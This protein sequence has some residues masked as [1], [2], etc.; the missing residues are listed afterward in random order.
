MDS[1]RLNNTDLSLQQDGG[2]KITK[3]SRVLTT[4]PLLTYHEAY[5]PETSHP[6]PAAL[7][8]INRISSKA[9]LESLADE[10]SSVE[11]NSATLESLSKMST[12]SRRLARMQMEK[13]NSF[14]FDKKR[15]SSWATLHRQSLDKNLFKG[16]LPKYSD[17]TNFVADT[18]VGVTKSNSS[19]AKMNST[20]SLLT[21]ISGGSHSGKRSPGYFS[22]E[23]RKREAKTK[24]RSVSSPIAPYGHEEYS[25]DVDELNSRVEMSARGISDASDRGPTNRVTFSN[26]RI[27]M[28]DREIGDNPSCSSGAPI[29]IGWSYYTFENSSGTLKT[30]LSIS[31]DN[32]ERARGPRSKPHVLV[33]SREVREEMLTRSGYSKWDIAEAVRKNVKTKRQR[34]QTINNLGMTDVEEFAEKSTKFFRKVFTFNRKKRRRQR[35]KYLFEE[36]KKEQNNCVPNGDKVHVRS[37]LRSVD[38]TDIAKV[39][40][41][42]ENAI[43][44]GHDEPSSPPSEIIL[45]SRSGSSD[46]HPVGTSPDT[47]EDMDIQLNA[48]SYEVEN[49]PRI[50][51]SHSE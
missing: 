7:M 20:T 24:S 10:V 43:S 45:E 33:L 19:V 15:S 2:E 48:G 11:S 50:F 35:S 5:Q 1:N 51:T 29:G 26:I 17:E 18:D 28:Y 27:R 21:K 44:L 4:N 6:A 39:I 40:P 16:V 36:W 46:S 8:T 49:N 25:P 13:N 12:N 42:F 47:I 14:L 38:S 30:D 22:R 23:S 34:R 3:E 32:Y 37:I 41:D 9:S 31:V